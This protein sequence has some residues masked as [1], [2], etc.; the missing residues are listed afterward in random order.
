MTKQEAILAKFATFKQQNLQ[1]PRLC[2]FYPAA[3]LFM[4]F[5]L[6]KQV[7]YGTCQTHFTYGG[8]CARTPPASN[9]CSKSF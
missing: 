1:N 3:T 8:V 2:F 9:F 6:I 4:T 5:L 7:Y